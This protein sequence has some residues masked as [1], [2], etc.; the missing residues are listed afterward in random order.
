M[1][2]AGKGKHAEEGMQGGSKC[3]GRRCGERK[4]KMYISLERSWRSE[5]K[6][7]VGGNGRGGGEESGS[8]DRS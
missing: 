3:R 2:L 5:G 1:R 4:E 7:R 8:E 6:Q